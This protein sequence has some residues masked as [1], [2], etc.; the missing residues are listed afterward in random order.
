MDNSTSSRIWWFR[1]LFV[2]L[3]ISLI[4]LRLLPLE[5][6]PKTW[7][8]PDLLLAL[9]FAWSMRRPQAIPSL[10]IAMVVLTEDMMLHRGPGLQAAL[11][12]TAAAWLKL[13]WSYNPDMS[14]LREWMIVALA[15]VGVMLATRFFLIVFFVPLPSL[16][17][18]LSQMFMTILIYPVVAVFSHFML[19]LRSF[20]STDPDYAQT[21]GRS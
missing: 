5:T 4:F 20:G 11:V 12:V 9:I 16:G 14:P 7:A 19:G 17:L 10:L 2:V 3:A 18:H 1:V 15:I 13:T 6:L 21:R 8:G